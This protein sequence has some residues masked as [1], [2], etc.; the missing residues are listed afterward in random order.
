MLFVGTLQVI[1]NEQV[2]LLVEL[3][4]GAFFSS[5][6]NMIKEEMSPWLSDLFFSV[7]PPTAHDDGTYL[8]LFLEDRKAPNEACF[9]DDCDFWGGMD[10][11]LL[12]PPPV[13]E[14]DVGPQRLS[15][16]RSH[17]LEGKMSV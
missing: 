8:L 17:G 14:R 4:I 5:L 9:D 11:D 7:A 3:I 16:W 15:E 12:Y 6:V 2:W 13:E 1:E 10:A